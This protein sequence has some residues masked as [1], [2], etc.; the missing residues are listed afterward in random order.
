MKISFA[1]PKCA[2]RLSIDA[3]LAGRSGR[4]RSCGQRIVIPAASDAAGGRSRG[5][6]RSEAARGRDSGGTGQA[7]PQDELPDWR[8]AVASQLVGTGSPATTG[9]RGGAGVGRRD[10][11]RQATVTSGYSLRPVTPTAVPT[12][13]KAATDAAAAK[14]RRRDAAP[15]PMPEEDF[16]PT[17]APVARLSPGRGAYE[18]T[19]FVQAYRWAFGH[20]VRV[21]TWISETS[22]TISFIVIILAIACGMTGRHTLAQWGTLAIIALNL[23]GLAGDVASLVILSFRRSPL[24]GALFLV[25]P[26]TLYYLWTDWQR[27]RD[28]VGR[29]RIPL[30]TLAAVA[31]AYLLVPWL[32]GGPAGDGHVT[33]AVERVI[34]E[35]EEDFGRPQGA[36][37]ETL[38]KARAWVRESAGEPPAAPDQPAD[39]GRPA[40]AG[41]DGG[42]RPRPGGGP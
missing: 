19:P 27:Y 18:P 2:S 24:Q 32:R 36:V 30:V 34:G 39:P 13:T 15:E 28:A 41:P 38:R 40:S 35:I 1:C 33:E 6:G 31:A 5:A 22:Y 17:A 16:E 21:S 11:G 42:D 3:A 29:M 7:A 4:C 25:P 23:V 14:A 37:E 10:G 12:L 20:L 8:T 26:F 9:Q